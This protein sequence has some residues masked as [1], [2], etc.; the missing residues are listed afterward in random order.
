M[1]GI[2]LR[3]GGFFEV[4]TGRGIVRVHIADS[5]KTMVRLGIEAPRSMGIVRDRLL[6]KIEAMRHGNLPEPV[7]QLATTSED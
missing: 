4:D 3:N 1:L 7:A 6:E 2:S 5:S